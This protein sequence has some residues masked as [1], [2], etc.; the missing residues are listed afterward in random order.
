MKKC[1]TFI[2]ILLFFVSNSFAEIRYV[3]SKLD[4]S[5]TGTLRQVI[6]SALPGDSIVINTLDGDLVLNGEIQIAKDIS[7]NGQDAVIRVNE[8]GVSTHRIFQLGDQTLQTRVA[9]GLYNMTLKGGNIENTVSTVSD[10]KNCGGCILLNRTAAGDP[11][12]LVLENVK[13]YNGSGNYSGAIQMEAN[14][15]SVIRNCHFEGN[16]ATSNNAGALYSKGKMLM[17]GCTFTDNS[18]GKD[19]AAIVANNQSTILNTVFL[20]NHASVIDGNNGGALFNASP[21]VL[22]AENCTFQ[23]NTAVKGGGG[24]ACSGDN[25]ATFLNCTFSGNTMNDAA[26]GGGAVCIIRGNVAFINC[27]LAGNSILHATNTKGAGIYSEHAASILTVTNCIVAHNVAGTPEEYSDIYVN[28]GSFRGTNNVIGTK[29]T[30]PEELTGDIPFSYNPESALFAAPFAL[31]DNGGTTPTIALAA[32]GSVAGEAGKIIGRYTT[33]GESPVVKFAFQAGEE[34]WKDIRS[35]GDVSEQ[36]DVID[37][38]QR[39]YTRTAG[40]NPCAGAYELNTQNTQLSTDATLQQLQVSPGTLTPNFDADIFRYTVD[41]A[42][43]VETIDVTGTATDANA[44]VEGN[45]TGKSLDVGENTVTITVRAED[46]LHTN[47]Y[48]VTV[49][50]Q[51]GTAISDVQKQTS[52]EVIAKDNALEM[53]VSKQGKLTVYNQQG[54][55][56]FDKTVKAGSSYTVSVMSGAVYLVKFNDKCTKVII[57]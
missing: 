46:N 23:D 50:R 38:D 9:V 42:Y 49:N 52:F 16:T 48:V 15:E 28:A 14:C 25:E 8:P 21:G 36:V 31:A 7:I 53:K 22:L 20:A 44:V 12:A 29:N 27:T 11:S 13:F 3:T 33:E 56:I 18:A 5:S 4:D 55:V 51:Q 54:S 17:D 1:F 35:N 34:S 6:E 41:V 19:G 30:S 40:K 26:R 2:A 24:F 32:S 45:V 39:G 43:D 47:D 10:V 37:S 57:R